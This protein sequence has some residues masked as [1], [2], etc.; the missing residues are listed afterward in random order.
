MIDSLAKK[1]RLTHRRKKYRTGA[2]LSR[3]VAK[4][5]RRD[6][7]I[8][9][10]S[11]IEHGYVVAQ[12]RTANV[13]YISKGIAGKCDFGVA[14]ILHLDQL[15][16]WGG[17]SWGGVEPLRETIPL[18][19]VDELQSA[20]ELVFPAAQ[21]EAEQVNVE[22]RSWRLHVSLGK[23]RIEFAWGPLSGFGG[24]E[25]NSPDREA[26]FDYCDDYLFSLEDAI[27]YAESHLKPAGT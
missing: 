16:R 6:I 4:D 19:T 17:K 11:G 15:W 18:I 27:S 25:H 7:K 10:D 21:F 22:H 26:S 13:H 23:R 3:F 9:D 1:M 24:I 12:V 5:V 14:E 8:I 20:L 2:E